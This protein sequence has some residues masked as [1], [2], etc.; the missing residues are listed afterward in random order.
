MLLFTFP[1]FFHLFPL[2]SPQRNGKKWKLQDRRHIRK[3]R[4]DTTEKQNTFCYLH[5]YSFFCFFY[6]ILKCYS[7][8]MK[9]FQVICFTIRLKWKRA[10]YLLFLFWFIGATGSATM[11]SNEMVVLV[12]SPRNV[13]PFPFGF[14]FPHFFHLFASLSLLFY[15][16]LFRDFLYR[17]S[18]KCRREFFSLLSSFASH[19]RPLSLTLVLPVSPTGR[20]TPAVVYSATPS[21]F[22]IRI[23]LNPFQSI[24]QSRLL[25]ISYPRSKPLLYICISHSMRSLDR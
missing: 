24:C 5:L 25:T 7:I 2:P 17:I 19:R 20:V 10:I 3:I 6:E 11:L 14:S 21:T 1:H 22:L 15:L 13:C 8:R 4:V 16:S 12:F 9:S 23:Y 18:D